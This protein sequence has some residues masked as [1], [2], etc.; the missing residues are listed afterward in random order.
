MLPL[1]S[2]PLAAVTVPAFSIMMAAKGMALYN[3]PCSAGPTVQPI[4]SRLLGRLWSSVSC[5]PSPEREPVAFTVITAGEIVA[6]PVTGT[7]LAATSVVYWIHGGR[8]VFF[9]LHMGPSS[10]E[11]THRDLCTIQYHLV[12]K[13]PT[14]KPPTLFKYLGLDASGVLFSP[15]NKYATSGNKS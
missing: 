6:L 13:S 10:P 9:W 2:H 4:N 12:P 7:A 1:F 3:G 8:R 11:G 14:A 15:A 5:L